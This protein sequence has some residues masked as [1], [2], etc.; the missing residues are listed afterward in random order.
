MNPTIH[1][2]INPG[3]LARGAAT[4]ALALTCALAA[5]SQVALPLKAQDLYIASFG[6]GTINEYA[7]SGTIIRTNVINGLF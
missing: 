2:S 5:L 6:N 3:P 4:L 1:T 7:L